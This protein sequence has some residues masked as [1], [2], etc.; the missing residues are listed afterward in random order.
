M[1]KYEYNLKI[2][3]NT[4]KNFLNDQEAT[5]LDSK[6]PGFFKKNLAN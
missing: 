4:Q 6:F 3:K 5:A 2:N 1:I